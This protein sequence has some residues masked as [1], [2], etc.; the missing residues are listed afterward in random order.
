MLQQL[1]NDQHH[2]HDTSINTIT[3]NSDQ[4]FYYVDGP[5]GTGKAFL[6]NTIVHKIQALR[7]KVNCIAY[8]GT[9]STLLINGATTHSTSRIPIPVLPNSKCNLKVIKVQELKSSGKEQYLFG[10]RISM[11]P[12]NALQ[13]VNVLIRDITEVNKPFGGKFMLL[14]G[15]SERFSQLFPE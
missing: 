10:M 8:S 14:G 11:I 7:L 15:G 13:V 9:A 5:A 12:A 6:Y 3:K 1:N 4:N 2:I